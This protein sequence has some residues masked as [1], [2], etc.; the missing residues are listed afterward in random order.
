MPGDGIHL[1]DLWMKDVGFW[2][3]YSEPAVMLKHLGSFAR[4]ESSKGL[5]TRWKGL[6]TTFV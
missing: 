4:V 1:E 2:T 5:K 3:A 6:S